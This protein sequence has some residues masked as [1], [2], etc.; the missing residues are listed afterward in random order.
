M[1]RLE[2]DDSKCIGCGSCVYKD[3]EHFDFNDSQTASVISNANLDAP[4]LQEA[5]D[6]CPTGAISIND[7]SDNNASQNCQCEN[8]DCENCDCEK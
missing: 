4:E 3:N 7:A 1:K 8:C 6:Y 2:I 5:I